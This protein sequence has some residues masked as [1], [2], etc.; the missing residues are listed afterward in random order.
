LIHTPRSYILNWASACCRCLTTLA[1]VLV[2]TACPLRKSGLPPSAGTPDLQ[3]SA[4]ATGV[5]HTVASNEN[6]STIAKTYQVDLQQIAEVNNLKPPYL[7]K[8][9]SVIFI[10]GATQPEKADL[11]ATPQTTDQGR[12]EDY[13]D[14]LQWPVEGEIISEFGVAKGVQHNGISIHAAEGTPVKAAAEGK[15]GHVGSIPGLGNVIL[16]EHANRLVTVY[17]HLK[18]IRT[19]AGDQVHTGR[20]V[21]TV[22]TSGRVDKPSL[23]FEVRSRSKP[24]NPLFFLARKP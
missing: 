24:R 7:I 2:L 20:V 13:P 22:G 9:K 23:Y 10:P 12:I 8:D 5:Y 4:P 14:L 15:I 16:I 17:A 18:E 21:G 6:L 1:I 3:P 11:R 19:K